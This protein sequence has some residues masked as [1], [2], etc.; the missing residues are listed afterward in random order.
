MFRGLCIALICLWSNAA[1]AG[2]RFEGTLEFQ[3]QGCEQTRKCTIKNEFGYVDSEGTGWQAQKDLETDGASIPDWAQLFIGGPF[4]KE[5]IRAA[6]IHDHYCW[7]NVRPWRKT[8]W[9]FYDALIAS[10]VDEAKAKLMYYAVYLR[11]PKWIE[12]IAG[13]PCGTGQNCVQDERMF[14]QDAQGKTSWNLPDN[15]SAKTGEDGKEYAVRKAE[16]DDPKLTD[17]LREVETLINGTN[18]SVSL[19]TLEQ[20]AESK[21]PGD[22]F[23][24]QTAVMV[25]VPTAPAEA[26][27]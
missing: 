26:T 14:K 12:L 27:K 5:F 24:N 25:S 10:G 1:L 15:S 6:V 21:R 3:P 17:D 9:V 2:G 7:R 22:F 16:F 8:H 13:R 20:L 18:G 19:Q 23:Y 11:G 4:A